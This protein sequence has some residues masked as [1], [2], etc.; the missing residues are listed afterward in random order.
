[1]IVGLRASGGTSPHPVLRMP[2]LP[3]GHR[4][5]HRGHHRRH[6]RRHHRGHHPGH[7]PDRDDRSV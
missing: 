7:R 2:A 4:G 5:H 3:A 1:M 6:H